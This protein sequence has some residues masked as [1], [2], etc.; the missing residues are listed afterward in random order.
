MSDNYEFI[1]LQNRIKR[2][3]TSS[4]ESFCKYANI[5]LECQF[6]HSHSFEKTL[7]VQT[8]FPEISIISILDICFDNLEAQVFR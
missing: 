5:N 3:N 6:F 1:I 8:L 2:S 7:I 4:L